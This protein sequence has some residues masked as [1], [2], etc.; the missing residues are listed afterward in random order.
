PVA[1]RGRHS[2]RHAADHLERSAESALFTI[3]EGAGAFQPRVKISC[4]EIVRMELP[5]PPAA[6]AVQQCDETTRPI[7]KSTSGATQFPEKHASQ[8]GPRSATAACMPSSGRYPSESSLRCARIS[9]TVWFAPI[10]S[11]LVG[12]SM[13]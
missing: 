1:Q 5:P 7:F 4:Y 3:A 6:Q 9:S 12:M 10:S 8:N 2:A 13:P 11:A